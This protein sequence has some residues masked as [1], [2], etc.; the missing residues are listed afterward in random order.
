MSHKQSVGE[1]LLADQA[2]E[3]LLANL[4]DGALVAGQ[5]LSMPELVEVL[6]LPFAAIR[7][8]VRRGD[9]NG[10]VQVLPKRGVVIMRADEE[11]TRHCMDMRMLLDQEG[12][13]RL[14]AT[15]ADVPLAALRRDHLDLID[16]AEGAM[17]PDLPRRAVLIDLSLH[18]ALSTG[19]DNP[20]LAEI[21]QVNRV[22]IAVI[23]NTRPFL[24]DRIVPEM[25]EH[26]TI[27][28][29]LERRDTEATVVAITGHHRSTL[30]WLGYRWTPLAG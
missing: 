20:L 28:E 21:Y 6:D 2:Y 17:T 12:A 27:I 15:H 1:G 3:R 13:R 9:V 8:A 16:A 7:A 18:D 22:R 4:R 24:P 14:I 23:Q 29:A 30:R 11:A 25:R 26:L 19:L 10:L 5:L